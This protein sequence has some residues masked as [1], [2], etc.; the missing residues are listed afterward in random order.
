[1]VISN[2]HGFV[3]SQSTNC[4]S[5]TILLECTVSPEKSQASEPTPMLGPSVP[6]TLAL[7]QLPAGPRLDL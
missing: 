3:E 1:M 7:C 6:P 2:T 4:Y 5:I